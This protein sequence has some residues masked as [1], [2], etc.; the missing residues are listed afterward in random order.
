[1]KVDPGEQGYGMFYKDYQVAVLEYLWRLPGG[2]GV[3]SREVWKGV[4]GDMGVSISRTSVINF[5]NELV[6][7]EML[8]FR[9]TTGKGGHYRIYRHRYGESEF[10]RELARRLLDRLL[11]ELP[12]ATEKAISKHS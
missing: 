4:N 8:D 1:M 5:L 2:E 12:E 6:D 10:R 7:G 11:E 3:G 9:E